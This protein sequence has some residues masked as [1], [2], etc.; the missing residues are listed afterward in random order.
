MKYDPFLHA[1]RDA[2]DDLSEDLNEAEYIIA[3]KAID[4]LLDKIDY[5][6]SKAEKVARNQETGALTVYLDEHDSTN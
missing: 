6:L 1:R 3:E 2:L 5:I 4:V